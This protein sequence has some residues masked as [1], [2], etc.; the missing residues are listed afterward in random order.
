MRDSGGGF[1][2]IETIFDM[3]SRI[4]EVGAGRLRRTSKDS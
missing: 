1:E 4:F 3:L 2:E